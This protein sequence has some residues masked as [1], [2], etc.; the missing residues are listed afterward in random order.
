MFLQWI[1]ILPKIFFPVELDAI[2]CKDKEHTY[3]LH[4]NF[5]AGHMPLIQRHINVGQNHD[6]DVTLLRRCIKVMCPLGVVRISVSVFWN[7]NTWNIFF[8]DFCI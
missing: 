7:L 6:V 2:W 4:N 8:D 3:K 5:P 1:N